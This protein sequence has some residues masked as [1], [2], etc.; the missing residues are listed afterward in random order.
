[1]TFQSFCFL[2]KCL[3]RFSFFTFL[4]LLFYNIIILFLFFLQETVFVGYKSSMLF[5]IEYF[6]LRINCDLE[7]SVLSL[8]T[9]YVK[10]VCGWSGCQCS[11]SFKS[12]L[13]H[14]HHAPIDRIFVYSR[15]QR[16]PSTLTK[17]VVICVSSLP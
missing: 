7:H 17:H 4:Y 3:C 5:L 8:A 6:I 13:Y 12:I 2:K 15:L 1:M 9:K 10:N 16:S 14:Y 11:G